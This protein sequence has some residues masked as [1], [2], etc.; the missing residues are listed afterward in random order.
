[1]TALAERED[2]AVVGHPS[3]VPGG[4]AHAASSFRCFKPAPARKPSEAPMTDTLRTAA[5]STATI[6]DLINRA[7]FRLTGDAAAVNGQG[8]FAD[9]AWTLT[10]LRTV[11]TLVAQAIA[12]HAATNW[13]SQ[14]DY[15]AL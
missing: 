12:R 1:M 14:S 13:P 4:P 11:E 9:P 10:Q 6:L 8:I 2:Q 3:G 7:A 5:I 15:H